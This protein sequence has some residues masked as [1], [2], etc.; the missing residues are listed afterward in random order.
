MRNGQK[1]WTS[2][3][4]R[5]PKQPMVIINAHTSLTNFP[6]CFAIF[7]RHSFFFSLPV[8]LFVLNKEEL[9][10]YWICNANYIRFTCKLFRNNFKHSVCERKWERWTESGGEKWRK[11]LIY[12]LKRKLCSVNFLIRIYSLENLFPFQGNNSTAHAAYLT[13]IFDMPQTT[14]TYQINE[15]TNKWMKKKKWTKADRFKCTL[16]QKKSCQLRWEYK[17]TELTKSTSLECH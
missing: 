9:S 12:R 16:I 3:L 1:C 8:S 13:L 14:A 6:A 10:G 4:L 17:S 7:I 5:T 2:F 15:R 11:I